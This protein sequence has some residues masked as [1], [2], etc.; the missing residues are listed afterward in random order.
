MGY[1]EHDVNYQSITDH[2]QDE[3]NDSK[4]CDSDLNVARE[5]ESLRGRLCG[6]ARHV[7]RRE[8]SC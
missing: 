6:I 8:I 7:G 1:C 5:L 4:D 3:N 2:C